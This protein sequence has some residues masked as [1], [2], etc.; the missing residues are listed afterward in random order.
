MIVI[1]S[2]RVEGKRRFWNSDS[3]SMPGSSDSAACHS[4]PVYCAG[5]LECL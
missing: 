5:S 2:L 4:M 1:T 3:D